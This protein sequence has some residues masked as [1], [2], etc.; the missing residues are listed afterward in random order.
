MRVGA[1]GSPVVASLGHVGGMDSGEGVLDRLEGM[2]VFLKVVQLGSF[3]AAAS[4]LGMSKSTVS[5]HVSVLE[6]RLGMR[7]LNRTTRRLSLTEGGQIYRD[8]I[9]AVLDAVE[10]ADH[11]VTHLNEAPRGLLRINAPMSF[12]LRHL[13]PL[14]PA[15]L[16]SY[17]EVEIDIALNDRR[18]DL[19]DE[20]FDLA[21]RIGDLEDSSLIARKLAR[22]RMVCV[23]S[24]AYLARRPAPQSPDDLAGHDCLRYNYSRNPGEWLFRR[25]G[26]AVRVRIDGRLCANNGDIIRE[27]LLGGLGVAFQP[28]FLVADAIDDGRL[29]VLLDDWQT[30]EIAVHAVYPESRHVSPKLRVFIDYLATHLKGIS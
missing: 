29:R 16:E 23:A 18:V 7:L 9:E 17:P 4:Q 20:G 25:D 28:S 11:A 27:A 6:E 22:C 24:P 19:V 13:G 8:R 2:G 14:L 10:D 26:N 12:G 15:F 3:S 5:K 1:H 30:P 21:V